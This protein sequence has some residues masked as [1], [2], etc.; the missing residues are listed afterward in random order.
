[1]GYPDDQLA[2]LAD[3]VLADGPLMAWLTVALTVL[4]VAYL[5]AIRGPFRAAPSAR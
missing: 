1:M 3:T 4:T 5:I 2:L